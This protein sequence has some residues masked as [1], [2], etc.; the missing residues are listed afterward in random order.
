MAFVHLM[1]VALVPPP[2]LPTIADVDEHR[3][4]R[5]VHR[6][7][8]LGRLP[9]LQETACHRIGLSL[10]PLTA[11]ALQ[12][13][14]HECR[15]VCGGIRISLGLRRR[16]EIRLDVLGG[17]VSSLAL[18]ADATLLLC[19]RHPRCMPGTRR[20][21]FRVIALVPGTDSMHFRRR[22]WTDDPAPTG[23]ATEDEPAATG[24]AAVAAPGDE[25][26]C[27]CAFGTASTRCGYRKYGD[28]MPFRR[29]S[30][31]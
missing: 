10:R 18:D 29:A 12:T 31:R 3:S 16:T 9:P 26:G 5:A 19:I 22:L 8:P 7:V 21:G 24:S 17:N 4:D 6:L 20:L 30:T 27:A 25:D 28:A 23:A 13:R 1:R 15:T 14:V 2:T 11:R